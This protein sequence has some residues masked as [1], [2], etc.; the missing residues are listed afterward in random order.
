MSHDPPDRLTLMLRYASGDAS[1][2]DQ[3]ALERE[4]EQNPAARDE[5]CDLALEAIALSE[6]QSDSVAQGLTVHTNSNDDSTPHSFNI[7]PWIF[8]LVA[9]IVFALGMSFTLS[10]KRSPTPLP[11]IVRILDIKGAVRWTGNGGD[12]NGDLKTQAELPG[13]VIETLSDDASV[14][15]AFNDNTQITLIGNSKAAISEKDQQKKIYFDAGN[16]AAQV[17]KQPPGRPLTIDTPTAF[18]EV[19][20]TTFDVETVE[21]ATVLKVTKGTVRI[22]RR[23]DGQTIDVAA[24]YQAVASVHTNKRLRSMKQRVHVHTWKSSLTGGFLKDVGQWIPPSNGKPGRLL[25][26]PKLTIGSKQTPSLLYRVALKIKPADQHYLKLTDQT[27]V[28]V[29]GRIQRPGLVVFMLS[30]N[31]PL[32]G[33]GGNFFHIENVKTSGEWEFEFAVAKMFPQSV[34][35]HGGSA[36]GMLTS[37]FII[38]THKNIGLEIEQAEVLGPPDPPATISDLKSNSMHSITR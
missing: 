16:L 10:L 11:K 36:V 2:E 28:R 18:L 4:L 25:A 21:T 35:P 24:G 37:S 38:Y 30:T 9:M 20:G 7:L 26:V 31:N 8:S 14:V 27:R 29:K 34:G 5:M 6:Q 19:L 15:L 23:A 12:V 17:K 1:A 3:A 32:G 13:G 33:Y 22:T